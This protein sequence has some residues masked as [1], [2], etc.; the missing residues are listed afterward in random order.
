M[1][2]ARLRLSPSWDET[3]TQLTLSLT[4]PRALRSWELVDL[5]ALV[6]AWTGRPARVALPAEAPCEWL[7]EWSC[8]LEGAL[9]GA[10]EVEFVSVRR[11]GA[12]R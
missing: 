4:L 12:R 6:R 5:C 10:V 11:E 9:D 3:H 2:P 7:D 1:N 8:V